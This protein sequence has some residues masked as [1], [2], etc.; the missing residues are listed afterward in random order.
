MMEMLRD[1]RLMF[2]GDSVQRGMFESMVCLVQSALPSDLRM[3]LQRIPPRKVFRVEVPK[4]KTR[5]SVF[6]WS[7]VKCCSFISGIQC[8]HR[9]LLGAFLDRIHIGSCYEPHCFQASGEARLRS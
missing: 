9:V 7:G 3:S 2:V 6:Y 1:K 5:L 8:I 4:K